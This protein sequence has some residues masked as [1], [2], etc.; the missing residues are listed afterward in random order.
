MCYMDLDNYIL[1]LIITS[2]GTNDPGM[3][4][5]HQIVFQLLDNI[6]EQ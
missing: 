5:L 3:K 1:R 2:H 6:T 4:F